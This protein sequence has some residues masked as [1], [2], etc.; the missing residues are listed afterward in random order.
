[1]DTVSRF[2]VPFLKCKDLPVKNGIMYLEWG[3][4]I[5]EKSSMLEQ[6]KSSPKHLKNLQMFAYLYYVSC[7]VISTYSF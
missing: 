6:M 2:L 1:M 7:P 4:M 3:Q 5:S